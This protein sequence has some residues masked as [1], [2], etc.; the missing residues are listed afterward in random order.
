[1]YETTSNIK[2]Y[3]TVLVGEWDYDERRALHSAATLAR[4]DAAPLVGSLGYKTARTGCCRDGRCCVDRVCS[5][6]SARVRQAVSLCVA[7]S[8]LF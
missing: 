3:I 8:A 6:L 5:D 1:M 4:Q 2:S 7:Q